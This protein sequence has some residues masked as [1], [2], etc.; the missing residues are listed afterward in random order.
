MVEQVPPNLKVSP[1]IAARIYKNFVKQNIADAYE[2]ALEQQLVLGFIEPVKQKVP[3]QIW[4][5]HRSVI[6][7]E[8]NI[9]TK[10]RPVFNCSFKMGKAQSSNEAAFHGIDLT[11]NLLSFLSFLAKFLHFIVQ[12]C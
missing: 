5:P 11:N 6:R 10:I 12:H 4:I 3:D 7:K 8:D 9:T 1:A 2:E